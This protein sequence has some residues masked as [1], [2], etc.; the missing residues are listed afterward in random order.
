MVKQ[1]SRLVALPPSAD[2]IPRSVASVECNP[3]IPCAVAT[4]SLHGQQTNEGRKI[5]VSHALVLG[6]GKTTAQGF[7]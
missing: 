3:L 6:A 5:V 1:K 7:E 4:E 2:E